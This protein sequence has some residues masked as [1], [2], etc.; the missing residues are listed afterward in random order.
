V[1]VN[2]TRR[3]TMTY[4]KPEVV[5]LDSAVRAIQGVQKS[6]Q[7]NLDN[8]TGVFNATPAAYEADE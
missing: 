6:M 4:N 8:R 5:K 3:K 7:Q 2:K 1:F